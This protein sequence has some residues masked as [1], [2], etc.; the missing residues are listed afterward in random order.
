MKAAFF[1]RPG[2]ANEVLKVG[3]IDTVQPAK[4]EVQIEIY[5][6]GVNPGEVKKRADTFGLGMPYDLIIPHSDGAGTITKIGHDV[7]PEWLGKRVLC[8]GAQS[9]RPFGTSANY[10]CVPEHNVVEIS[11]Q[12]DMKQAAQMG[13]PGITGFHCVHLGRNQKMNRTG[14]TLLVQGGGGAVGQCAIAV[15]LDSG[16]KVIASVRKKEDLIAAENAGAIKAYLAD[17]NMVE[18]IVKDYPD[19]IDHIVE[20][21]FDANIDLDVKLLKNGGSI[22]TYASNKSP[23]TIPFWELV[24]KNIAIHFLGSDDFSKEAK[25][26]AAQNLSQLLDHGWK[27]LEIG[28]VYDLKNIADAHLHIENGLK[29][30][31]LIRVKE[32]KI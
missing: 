15:A 28:K 5:Y 11:D 20:V 32:E 31:A 25:L 3:E 12:V 10:C 13:I 23:S 18:K 30:R 7:S 6:S 9:Y 16:A 21:A 2:E 4:N 1:K 8:F 22:A 29:G 14:Q 26:L 24:F 17:E 19:G 27:G